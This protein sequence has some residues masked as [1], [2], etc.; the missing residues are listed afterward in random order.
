MGRHNSANKVPMMQ[1]GNGAMAYFHGA[2]VQRGYGLGGLLSG[3][4]RSAVPLLKRGAKAVG[5]TLLSSGMDVA[6]DV[7]SGKNLKTSVKSRAKEATD[8]LTNQAV[9][10]VQNTL[11][12]QNGRGKKST[13]RLQQQRLVTS[14]KPVG[15]GA[16]KDSKGPSKQ[17]KPASHRG[18]RKISPNQ[19]IFGFY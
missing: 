12:R 17:R 1:V 18:G 7:L 6:G 5:K 10:R 8:Q 13:K 4:W 16:S 19:D 2:P 3:L 15:R 9:K 11:S 14:T